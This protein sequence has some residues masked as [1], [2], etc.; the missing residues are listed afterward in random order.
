[1]KRKTYEELFPGLC[2]PVLISSPENI[3]YTI[4]FSTTARRPAQIGWNAVIM[5][6][7][8]TWFIFPRAWEPLVKEQ[9]DETQIHLVSYDKK[10]GEP[11]ETTACLLD[12]LAGNCSGCL[13]IERDK[14]EL[15]LY[16]SLQ[17]KLRFFGK[18][19]EWTDISPSLLKA[20]MI[21]SREEICALRISAQLAREAMEYAKTILC[22]G[23]REREIVAA[24][25]YFMRCRGS[26]GVPFT[27]K[28]LSGE[29]STRTVNLPGERRLKPG[30][31]VLL[32]F[33]SV[34]NH[35][36][37]DWTRSFALGEAS[38]ALT[39][40]YRLVWKIERECIRLIRP[41]TNFRDLLACAENILKGHPLEKWFNPYLGHSIGI[42]SQEWPDI[43][44]GADIA[45]QQNMVITIEPG[46]Y[47]PGLGGVRIE[48]EVLV[49]ADGGEI[50]TGLEQEGFILPERRKHPA[51]IP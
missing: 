31:V 16:L 17:E 26:E 19:R 15:D 20:R 47:V 50:L 23:K 25:E 34:V 24:L 18:S 29:N 7:A 2:C 12:S 3:F 44:P 45:L 46:I 37:S 5:T 48:D 22:P 35:Y 6:K 10:P 1:M 42:N 33:G 8:G 49:T 36:A 4:G 14:L 21:K 38:P 41:G 40:L 32:D 27:M 39:E 13:G 51:G 11:S 9:I 43:V 30:E 28:V